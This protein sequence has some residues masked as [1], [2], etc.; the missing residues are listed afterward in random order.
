MFD[1]LSFSSLIVLMS[2]SVMSCI[3]TSLLDLGRDKA[4]LT[5]LCYETSIIILKIAF[6]L[7]S[8]TGLDTNEIVEP[9]GAGLDNLD[10][11]I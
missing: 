6:R 9:Y 7:L 4:S 8:L 5:C 11:P 1:S 2:S 10:D 3:R